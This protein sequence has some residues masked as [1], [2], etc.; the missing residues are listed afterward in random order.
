MLLNGIEVGQLEDLIQGGVY[1]VIIQK[2]L[3]ET[4]KYVNN[5]FE[6]DLIFHLILTLFYVLVSHDGG[7]YHT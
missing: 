3:N 1:R 7:S 5:N 2:A 4:D 6:L